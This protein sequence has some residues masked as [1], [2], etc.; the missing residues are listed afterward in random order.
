MQPSPTDG[1]LASDSASRLLT[2]L[3]E[4]AA[5]AVRPVDADGVHDLRVAV[6]RFR[7]WLA[8]FG[9]GLPRGDVKRMVRRLK[10]IMDCA[11]AVRDRD[12]TLKILAKCHVAGV[13]PLRRKLAS[14]RRDAARALAAEARRWKQSRAAAKWRARIAPAAASQPGGDLAKRARKYLAHGDAAADEKSGAQELHRFRIEGKKLRYTIELLAPRLGAAAADWLEKLKAIQ[15]V[16]GDVHDA[17]MAR[18]RA[19]RLGAAAPVE[20]W[21]KRRQRKKIRDFRAL[22]PQ[23]FPEDQH[24]RL[25]AALRHTPRKPMA[26]SAA[27]APAAVAVKRA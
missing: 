4:Q 12:V 23:A 7:Q 10:A 27:D 1:L 11:G 18:E 24:V 26:R 8:T 17:R 19:E 2:R 6:R 21:L 5:A 3:D 25:V 22:W 16:L 9:S 14:E 15:T 13:A 20:A